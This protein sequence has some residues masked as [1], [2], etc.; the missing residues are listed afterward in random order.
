MSKTIDLSKTV[1][2]VFVLTVAGSPPRSLYNPNDLV[3]KPVANGAVV[4]LSAETWRQGFDLDDTITEDGVPQ[5]P[6]T[7][8]TD[9]VEYLYGFFH[10]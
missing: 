8:S 6:F 10:N 5:G 2:N 1:D 7:D 4:K 3:V 9:L